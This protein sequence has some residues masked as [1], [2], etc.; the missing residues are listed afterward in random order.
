MQITDE[1]PVQEQCVQITEL[2]YVNEK[3]M[4]S[5]KKNKD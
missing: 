5:P 2:H 3:L 4:K 1:K